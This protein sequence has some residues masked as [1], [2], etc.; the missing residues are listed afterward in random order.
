MSIKEKARAAFTTAQLAFGKLFAEA[1][2]VVSQ[3]NALAGK[4]A[5]TAL[6]TLFDGIKTMGVQITSINWAS[7]YREPTREVLKDTG[8]YTDGSLKVIVARHYR[9][10]VALSHGIA[11]MA[12]EA[13]IAYVKRTEEQCVKAGWLTKANTG[14]ARAGKKSVKVSKA[15]KEQRVKALAMVVGAN[16]ADQDAVAFLVKHHMDKLRALY[17]SVVKPTDIK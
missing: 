10:A 11:P 4:K 7:T 6:T 3:A 15:T 9:A 1:D 5:A 13:E 12:G 16:K 2:K 17:A 14:G 8:R